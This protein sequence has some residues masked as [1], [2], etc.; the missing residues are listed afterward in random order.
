MT[1]RGKITAVMVVLQV[2]IVVSLG[3]VIL[4]QARVAVQESVE[5]GLETAT[6]FAREMV[7]LS[8][9]DGQLDRERLERS[10]LSITLGQTGYPYV[11]DA[12]GTLV[13]HPSSTGT[14]L[15]DQDHIQ[16]MLA[17]QNG[18]IAYAQT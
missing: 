6:A 12:S 14:D 16:T 2:V 10:L 9:H 17:E 4:L 13:I 8:I 3:T 1:I 11:I 7:E 18:R 15:S 5:S